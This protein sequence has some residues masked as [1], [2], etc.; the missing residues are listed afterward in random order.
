[1]DRNA[2]GGQIVTIVLGLALGGGI[3]WHLCAQAPG[4]PE[5]LPDLKEQVAAAL[6]E[7]VPVWSEPARSAFVEHFVSRLQADL[8]GTPLPTG[9]TA[10]IGEGIRLD[11][12][13]M[14]RR[15]TVSRAVVLGEMYGLYAGTAIAANGNLDGIG[16]Q[17]TE[18]MLSELNAVLV[19]AYEKLQSELLESYELTA[20]SQG[21]LE[22]RCR[23]GAATDDASR[24]K[25]AKSPLCP[26]AHNGVWR[27]AVAA[28]SSDMDRVV[29]S[30]V[31][32]VPEGLGDEAVQPRLLSTTIRRVEAG[33][34]RAVKQRL[35][36]QRPEELQVRWDEAAAELRASRKCEGDVLRAYWAQ[37]MVLTTAEAAACVDPTPGLLP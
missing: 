30:V 26:L 15:T 37:F 32:E 29:E 6:V 3:V 35:Y 27:P 19:D 11:F 7:A 14:E 28:I 20:E 34:V 17:E 16:A 13:A 36:P 12:R 22:D 24:R 2:R 8:G 33:F 21:A 10:A 23:E 4:Q 25:L 9:S 18:A 1:M 31:A 5:S